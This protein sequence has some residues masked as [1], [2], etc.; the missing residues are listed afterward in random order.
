MR[1]RQV[2]QAS[3]RESTHQMTPTDLAE[4]MSSITKRRS[5]GTLLQKSVTKSLQA[6][7]TTRALH[8]RLRA[9]PL[10]QTRLS[11]RRVARSEKEDQT[12]WFQ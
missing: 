2:G 3:P 8:T 11:M 5:A 12:Q 9:S 4:E 7:I 6:C 10:L 1:H